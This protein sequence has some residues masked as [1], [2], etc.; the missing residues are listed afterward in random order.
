MGIFPELK[1][2]QLGNWIAGYVDKSI[3]EAISFF[4]QSQI[5]D[6]RIWLPGFALLDGRKSFKAIETNNETFAIVNSAPII[7][8]D[9]DLSQISMVPFIAIVSGDLPPDSSFNNHST[10]PAT[11]IED[12]NRSLTP[13]LSSA[14]RTRSKLGQQ[15]LE[16]ERRHLASYRARLTVSE[17]PVEFIIQSEPYIRSTA[18]G[19]TATIDVLTSDGEE[20][21]IY[22]SAKSI[23]EPL[24]DLRSE[25]GNIVGA[26][27]QIY[28]ESPD[29]RARFV[30]EFLGFMQ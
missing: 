26:R 5:Y 28:K 3:F 29:V 23:A 4:P 30:L 2:T 20:M 22:A 25:M 1:V 11:M 21:F 9:I 16:F 7:K 27:Y 17:T 24:E 18:L 15:E 8:L 12:L 10:S 19:Y 14:N 6:S 13:A